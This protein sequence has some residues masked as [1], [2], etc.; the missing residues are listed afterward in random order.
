MIINAFGDD[1]Q[2]N[3][4]ASPLRNLYAGNLY[5]DFFVAKRGSDERIERI[6]EFV[7]ALSDV[8]AAVTD[9]SYIRYSHIEIG[10]AIGF[11]T[12]LTPDL[13]RFFTESFS[14]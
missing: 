3:I 14:R 5:P 2:Q 12:F 13:K 6:N 7:T 1:E 10:D 11:D 9:K 4:Q 8:D